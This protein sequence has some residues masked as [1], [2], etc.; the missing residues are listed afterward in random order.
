M[1][2][3]Y[4]EGPTVGTAAPVCPSPMLSVPC[5]PLCLSPLI[6]RGLPACRK[7][8]SATLLCCSWNLWSLA[9]GLLPYVPMPQVL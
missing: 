9:P 2:L 7:P 5:T 4:P 8:T 1:A 3:F 6:L